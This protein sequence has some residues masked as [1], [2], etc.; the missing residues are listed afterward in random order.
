MNRAILIIISLLAWSAWAILPVNNIGTITD[1]NRNSIM[2]STFCVKGG[3]APEEDTRAVVIYHGDS[4]CRR[5]WQAVR[6]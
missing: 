3:H 4:L 2:L 5:H 6:P 1:T